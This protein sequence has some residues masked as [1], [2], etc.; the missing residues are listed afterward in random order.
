MQQ[1]VDTSSTERKAHP[2]VPI[3]IVVVDHGTYRQP[4]FGKKVN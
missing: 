1:E 2:T 3:S 4:V